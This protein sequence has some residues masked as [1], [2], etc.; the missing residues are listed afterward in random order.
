MTT[1]GK[2]LLATTILP[3]LGVVTGMMVM[4]LFHPLRLWMVIGVGVVW[5]LIGFG[6]G[7]TV[8]Q[9]FLR[10]LYNLEEAA[11]LIAAGRLQHR[12]DGVE[13]WDEVG[14]I[15]RQF[16]V[17]AE[18]IEE[19]V[20]TL[21]R[22]A[23]ENRRLAVDAEQLATVQERQRLARELH[24]SV[25]QQL[26]ALSM[27]ASSALKQERQQLPTLPNTVAQIAEI[28][29]TAQ[30]EMRAL[31]LHLR[32]IELQGRNF[33]EAAKSFLDAISDRHQ[34]SCTFVQK[35]NIA[36][37]PAVETQLFRILQEAVGNVLK[38]ADARTI[39]VTWERSGTMCTLSIVDDGKGIEPSDE[40]GDSYGIHAMKER[41]TAL[42]GRCNIWRIGQ[43]TA[44]EVQ[45][46]IIEERERSES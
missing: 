18:Q 5:L 3:V 28:A 17:M 35:T 22:L 40:V 15:G 6:I 32:P 24:D 36:L 45:L 30:R 19:Q 26:F 37:E 23:E 14:R 29:T 31:L 42:G 33:D 8:V 20:R 38:H 10:R 34:L 39:Q 16:N 1:R 13:E 43:G 12:I 7:Y 25:S 11:T 46:P 21:R 44:V 4:G 27:L 41:A 2:V 9:P